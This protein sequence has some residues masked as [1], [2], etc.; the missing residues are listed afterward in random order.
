MELFV[1]RHGKAVPHGSPEYA[2]NERPLTADGI[3]EMELIAKAFPELRVN[4]KRIVS[5]PFIR[6]RQTAEI[7]AKKFSAAERIDFSEYLTPEA[8]AGA[9]F[10]ELLKSPDVPES[11]MLVGHEPYLSKLISMLTTGRQDAGLDMKKAGLARLEVDEWKFGKS[12]VLNWL[13]TPKLL[14]LIARA[15]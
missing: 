8:D 13:L 1:L 11:M 7:A 4:P 10:E 2:E 14:R 3:E 12:A 5:S 9:F 6:A 15:D